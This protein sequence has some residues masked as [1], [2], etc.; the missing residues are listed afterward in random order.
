VAHRIRTGAVRRAQSCGRRDLSQA[1]EAES[2][3]TALCQHLARR[4]LARPP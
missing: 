4:D 2:P 3:E 1:D